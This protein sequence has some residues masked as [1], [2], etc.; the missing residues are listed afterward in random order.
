MIKHFSATGFRILADVACSL[1]PFSVLVG[2][3]ASGK[4]TLLEALK[5]LSRIAALRANSGG[6]TVGLNGSITFE[7]P[8]IQL[9]VENGQFAWRVPGSAVGGGPAADVPAV[10]LSLKL[11]P[12]ALRSASQLAATIDV[13]S[14]DGHGLP[15]LLADFK[16]NDDPRL[17][18]ILEMLRTIV[19]TI[20]AMR[21]VRDPGN[22]VYKLVFETLAA[23]EV[24]A[25]YV[26]DGT[27]YTLGYLAAIES[28]RAR[29]ALLLIDDLDQGLH[30]RAQVE[31]IGQLRKLQEV[32]PDLQIVATS[33]SPYL[34][35]CLA[36]REVRIVAVGS[37]HTARI[38]KLTDHP[39]YER[40]KDV[41]AP[42]EFWS[43][44][45]ESWVESA[46]AAGAAGGR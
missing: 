20:V 26:S 38:A 19:P 9:V 27:M 35:D 12:N 33:H 46:T 22:N 8:P 15:A 45:G 1:E 42:G 44:V 36:P 23:K 43:S 17:G 39:E 29:S 3:N 7:S 18:R 32:K 40:W 6:T 5:V 34:L 14:E 21:S 2:P 24:P 4:S 30:P 31:L 16:L 28:T 10:T 25:Q 41:M 37:D 13:L 11:N